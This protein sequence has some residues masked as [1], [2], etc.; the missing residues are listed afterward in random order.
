LPKGTTKTTPEEVA[1]IEYWMNHYPRKMFN[2][3][4]SYEMSLAG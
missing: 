4:S 1:A 3:K 2:Y